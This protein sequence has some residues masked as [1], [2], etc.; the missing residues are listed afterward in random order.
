MKAYMN[1]AMKLGVEFRRRR[2]QLFADLLADFGDRPLRILDL[3]GREAFWESMGF[4]DSG[5]RF[6]I[7]NVES[8]ARPPRNAGFEFVVGDARDLSGISRGDFDVV[9]SNSVIE[10]VGSWEDQRAMAREIDRVADCYYVQSPNYY[11]PL[12]P[13]FHVPFF[14]MLPLDAR[15]RLI[16][17]FALGCMPRLADVDQARAL[18][19]DTRLL[20]RHEIDAL[21]PNVE[22]VEERFAGL[23]KSFVVRKRTTALVK[24]ESV[25]FAE[26]VSGVQLVAEEA[27]G[28]AA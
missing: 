17:R 19:S 24:Q 23:T 13:H 26:P 25:A 2:F 8:E 11:F 12:E 22:V 21:F 28:L 5:H 1:H 14:Q 9:F 20:K 3:G 6:T 4:A 18:A 15:T 27:D 16:Q 7:L 10:H